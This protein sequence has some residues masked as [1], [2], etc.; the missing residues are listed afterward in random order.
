MPKFPPRTLAPGEAAA[1]VKAAKTA[2][3]KAIVVLLW[4]SGLRSAEACALCVD[5]C[6]TLDDG[7]MKLHVRHGKGDKARWV[8]LDKRSADFLRSTIGARQS[9]FV[10]ATS[11]GA[12]PQTSWIRKRIAVIAKEARI[13]GRVHPHG[14]RHTFARDMYDEGFRVRDIQVAL[15]HSNLGTTQNYLQS[16]GCAEVVEEAM[17]REW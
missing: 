5:D 15:G 11:S 13:T 4:R 14:L 6:T 7:A 8:G 17:R 16:I 1:M 12:A 10:L 2:R 9:G 3:E